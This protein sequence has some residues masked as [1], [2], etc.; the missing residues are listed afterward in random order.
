MDLLFP[1]S[2][3]RDVISQQKERGAEVLEHA[4][5]DSSHVTIFADYPEEYTSE[6]EHFLTHCSQD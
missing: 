3:A 6:V 5:K 2:Q 1:P 4:W